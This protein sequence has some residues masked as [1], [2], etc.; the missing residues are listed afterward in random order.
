MKAV[1]SKSARRADTFVYLKARDAFESLPLPLRERLG[2][3]SFVLE[4]ELTPQ[5]KL[6][7]ADADAVRASL[8]ERGYF[9]Q[10]PPGTQFPEAE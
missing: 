9:L 1:D 7:R 8:N 4:V 3:L 6:A 5:R 10:L 2:A